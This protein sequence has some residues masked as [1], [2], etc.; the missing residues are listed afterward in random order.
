MAIVA[1]GIALHGI[2]VYTS[3]CSGAFLPTVALD[4]MGTR[5]EQ[6]SIVWFSTLAAV[7]MVTR[8]RSQAPDPGL[9]NGLSAAQQMQAP[10]LKPYNDLLA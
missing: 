1:T 2:R 6:S 10:H 9:A 4:G 8:C 3:L 7:A 5:S